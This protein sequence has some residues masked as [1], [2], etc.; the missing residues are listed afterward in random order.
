FLNRAALARSDAADELGAVVPTLHSVE[1]AGFAE[2]LAENPGIVVDED[3]HEG[4]TL[5]EFGRLMVCVV[6][7]RAAPTTFFA[8]SVM[9]LAVVMFRPL[10]ASILRPCSTFVPSKRTTSGT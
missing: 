10:P 1:G 9:P 3:A 5:R 2:A 6:A 4:S 8:A 7:Y